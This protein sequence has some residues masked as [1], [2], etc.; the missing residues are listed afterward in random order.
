MRRLRGPRPQGRAVRLQPLLPEDLRGQPRQASHRG[1]EGRA[2]L[3]DAVH[4]RLHVQGRDLRARAAAHQPHQGRGEPQGARADLLGPAAARREHLGRRLPHQPVQRVRAGPRLLAL[5]VPAREVLLRRAEPQ[6]GPPRARGPQQRELAAL[7][8]RRRAV[9]S[10]VGPCERARQPRA[11]LRHLPAA[12]AGEAA[13]EVRG[14][15]ELLAGPEQGGQPAPRL[16]QAGLAQQ[17][18]RGGPGGEPVPEAEQQPGPRPRHQ[19]G[20]DGAAGGGQRAAE[21]RHGGQHQRREHGPGPRVRH[22]VSPGDGQ[23]RAL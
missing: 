16:Q 20:Q 11:R 12:E 21:A 3:G 23:T 14:Q 2:L 17:R 9:R 18:G 8:P 6:A 13:A 19:P 4:P 1:A 5:P 22:Q 15:R 7:R 10:A